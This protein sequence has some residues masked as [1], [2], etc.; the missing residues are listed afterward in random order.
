MTEICNEF[1]RDSKAYWLLNMDI[2]WIKPICLQNE[3]EK[4]EEF[5]VSS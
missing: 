1:F 3:Q 2:K 5:K 4:R